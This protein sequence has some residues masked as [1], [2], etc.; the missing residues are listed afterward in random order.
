MVFVWTGIVLGGL[1]GLLSVTIG[2]LPIT[3]TSSGGAL[4]GGL[5]FGWLRSL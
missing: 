5:V 4:I 2:G 1:V 3:L